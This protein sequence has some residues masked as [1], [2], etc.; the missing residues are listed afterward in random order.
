M[1]TIYFIYNSLVFNLILLSLGRGSLPSLVHLHSNF[2]L[3]PLC[4]LCDIGRYYRFF[5][6]AKSIATKVGLSFISLMSLTRLISNYQKALLWCLTQLHANFQLFSQS[7]L[8]C[9]L[10]RIST[11][12]YAYNRQMLNRFTPKSIQAFAFM[13]PIHVPKLKFACTSYSDFCKVCIKKK[14]EKKKKTKYF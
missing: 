7:G 5:N 9:R 13:P 11:L 2:Q 8:P 14:N 1:I 6:C 3:I 12:F 4:S 10:D